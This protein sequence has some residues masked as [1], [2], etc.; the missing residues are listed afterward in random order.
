MA[1]VPVQGRSFSQWLLAFIRAVYAPTEYYWKPNNIAQSPLPIAQ[2][3]EIQ[4]KIVKIEST[5]IDKINKFISGIRLPTKPI[6]KPNVKTEDVKR[7]ENIVIEKP[8]NETVVFENEPPVPIPTLTPTT[9]PTTHD[10][11]PTPSSEP[12]TQPVA[13]ALTTDLVPTPENANI[14]TGL[15]HT[16]DDKI[17]EGAIVEIINQE[18]GM[19]VRAL[20]S[21]KLGQFTI[22]T[23]LSP[24]KYI[25]S[26]ELDKYIFEPVLIE[27][28]N[29][30]IKPILIKANI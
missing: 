17:L 18:T 4:N 23:P 25:I 5:F 14:L 24:G 11:L 3:N 13:P 9:Y 27:V 12:I 1:F 10:P 6:V 22:A 8:K 21:N 7:V 2:D 19:P 16:H 28:K 29:E 15:V 26:S 30:I 20:R